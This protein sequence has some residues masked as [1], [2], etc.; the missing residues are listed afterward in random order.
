MRLHGYIASGFLAGSLLGSPIDLLA[1]DNYP[2]FM[3]REK[4]AVR[5][6]SPNEKLSLGQPIPERH[7]AEPIKLASVDYCYRGSV[8]DPTTGEMVDFYVMC[9]EDEVGHN[10]SVA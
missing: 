1:G 6:T 2:D 3:N 7:R 4:N 5:E 9:T 8:M 10:F